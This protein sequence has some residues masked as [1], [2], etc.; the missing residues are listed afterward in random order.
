METPIRFT[1]QILRE[2][3]QYYRVQEAMGNTQR[4][5]FGIER[6]SARRPL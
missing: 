2:E 1:L 5:L 3:Q 6:L 4:F